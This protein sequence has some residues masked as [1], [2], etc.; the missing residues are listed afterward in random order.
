[1]RKGDIRFIDQNGD[2]IINALDMNV[3][4]D[5]NPDLYGG[6]QTSL[7]F[8]NI[9]VGAFFTYS[10][11]NDIFNYVRFKTESMSNFYNQTTETQNRWGSQNPNGTIPGASFGDPTGN[12]VFSDRW[13]ENG[14]YL[15][16][17][18]FTLSYTLPA[19]SRLYQHA[20]IYLTG[21]N[22]I[23]FTRYKGYDPEVFYDNSPFQMGI[24]YGK[25]PQVPAFLLGLR[26]S[27]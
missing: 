7:I 19:S 17:K 10:Y 23:T 3:I 26:L 14:S 25:I 22:L 18:N 5:P 20:T 27:I 1:M 13:I 16:L 4:G 2:N 21:A 12:T 8:G 11:G 24:D 15:R 6:I 9:E